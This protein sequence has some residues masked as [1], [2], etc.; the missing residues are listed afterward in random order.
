MINN[1]VYSL[2]VELVR[3]VSC[4][5]YVRWLKTRVRKGLLVRDGK[6]SLEVHDL[7]AD[8]I[9]ELLAHGSSAVTT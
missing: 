4:W 2:S 5:G 9:T 1:A 6:K 8:V 3:R 7:I